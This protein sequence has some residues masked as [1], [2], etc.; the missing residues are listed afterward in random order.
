MCNIALNFDEEDENKKIFN[1]PFGCSI[2]FA[3]YENE[4]FLYSF[5]P[6]GSYRIYKRIAIGNGSESLWKW[7]SGI[8]D[9]SNGL[10]SIKM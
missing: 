3:G 2:L 7:T 6:S 8:T 4:P 9:V 10:V 5:D 1:R